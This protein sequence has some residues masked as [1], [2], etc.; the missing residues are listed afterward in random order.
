MLH[1]TLLI[2]HTIYAHNSNN[3]IVQNINKNALKNTTLITNPKPSNDAIK[4]LF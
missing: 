2:K 1:R 3:I 4:L